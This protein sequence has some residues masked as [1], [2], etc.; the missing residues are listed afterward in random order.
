MLKSHQPNFH[1]KEKS[2]QAIYDQFDDSEA[3]TLEEMETLMSNPKTFK[4]SRNLRQKD[5]NQEL[6]LKMIQE[7]RKS[8]SSDTMCVFKGDLLLIKNPTVNGKTN[9]AYTIGGI[10]LWDFG[11]YY[12]FD[13]IG[14]FPN[15]KQ[16]GTFFDPVS[17]HTAVNCLINDF[18]GNFEIRIGGYV[19]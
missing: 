4:R 16:H 1:S 18:A 15:G 12:G 5:F 17:L 6:H 13:K 10:Q 11:S 2:S 7:V 19:N 8:I 14:F 9:V 3:K